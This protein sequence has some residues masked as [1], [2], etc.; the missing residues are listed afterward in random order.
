M[1]RAINK[2]FLFIA[3]FFL[4]KEIIMP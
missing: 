3:Y 2:I 1:D 4:R